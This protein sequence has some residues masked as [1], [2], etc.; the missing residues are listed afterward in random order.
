M[1]EL[2]QISAARQIALVQQEAG[3]VASRLDDSSMLQQHAAIARQAHEE[4]VGESAGI[5]TCVHCPQP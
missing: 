3:R 2:E 4:T 5:C 1:L